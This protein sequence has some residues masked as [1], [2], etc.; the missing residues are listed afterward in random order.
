MHVGRASGALV[1]GCAECREIQAIALQN[2]VLKI[3]ADS[4]NE[5]GLPFAPSLRLAA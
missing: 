3:L 4:G 5:Q 2:L 1:R